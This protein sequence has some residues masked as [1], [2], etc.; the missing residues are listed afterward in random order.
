MYA[1]FECSLIPTDMSDKI[2]KREPNGACCYFV[3]TFDSSRNI[4]YTFEG[5]DCV[6]NVIERLRL[7]AS[8]CVKEQQGKREDDTY[9]RR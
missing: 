2:A 1:D 3:C 7:L 8:R 6:V 4:L 5:R 9:D